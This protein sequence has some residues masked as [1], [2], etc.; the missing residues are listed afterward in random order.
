VAE[1]ADALDSKANAMLGNGQPL[2][3]RCHIKRVPL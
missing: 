3:K 2:P 1:L